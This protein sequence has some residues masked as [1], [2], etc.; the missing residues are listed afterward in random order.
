[1][2][3]VSVV[4]STVK[5]FASPIFASAVFAAAVIARWSGAVDET[6]KI[7]NGAA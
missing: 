6:M 7:L 1:M 3:V 2:S 4:A 5:P